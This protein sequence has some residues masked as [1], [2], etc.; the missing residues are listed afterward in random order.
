[1]LMLNG[2]T[3]KLMAERWRLRRGLRC[4]ASGTVLCVDCDYNGNPN[5][6]NKVAEDAITLINDQ[7]IEI[8][9]LNRLLNESNEKIKKLKEQLV[10]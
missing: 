2:R 6:K 8:E 10:R 9:R 5:C 1:M 3:V 7:D 4:I